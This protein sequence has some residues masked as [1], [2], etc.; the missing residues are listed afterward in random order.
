ME[1]QSL[2]HIFYYRHDNQ[3][4]PKAEKEIRLFSVVRNEILR[5]PYFFQYY[6]N[7][8]IDRFFIIDNGSTDGTLTFLSKQK[9]THVFVTK[10]SFSKYKT[11]W[12]EYLLKKYGVGNW[13]LFMDADELL[14][15]PYCEYIS[16]KELCCYLDKNKFTAMFSFLL[17]MY[18]KKPIYLTHYR[19]GENFLKT[20]SYFDNYVP[21][22]FLGGMRRRVFNT[23]SG[24][25]KFVLFKYKPNILFTIGCHVLLH[26][27]FPNTLTGCILHFK[28]FADFIE[29]VRKEA[30]RQEYWANSYE[31][32]LWEKKLIENPK[33]SLYYP[34]ST[35]FINSNQLIELGLIK[36]TK[37]FKSAFKNKIKG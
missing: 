2:K 30:K 12:V 29:K 3:R 36:V 19:S 31:Y 34:K 28:Y 25:K 22:N 35:K 8:G 27:D 10:K 17:D 9:N 11:I 37:Q 5:L 21:K 13:C 23:D 6:K 14:C 15:Y 7:I 16:I 26:A 1:K 33:L 20:T 24:L 4:I 18:S 32:K